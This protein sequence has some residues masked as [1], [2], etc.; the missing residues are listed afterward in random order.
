MR[1]EGVDAGEGGVGGWYQPGAEL[2][3]PTQSAENSFGIPFSGVLATRLSSLFICKPGC[4]T[5]PKKD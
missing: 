1:L 3:P 4:S 5:L 2:N